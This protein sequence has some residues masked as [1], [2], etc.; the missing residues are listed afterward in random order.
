[1][2]FEKD[3]FISYAHIDEVSVDK[4][5]EGWISKFHETLQS[6]VAKKWGHTP[7]IWRDDRLKGND[8]F[9]P[10]ILSQFPKLKLLVSIITP[11][12]LES[13]WCGFSNFTA[14][15][16][17]AEPVVY[18]FKSSDGTDFYRRQITIDSLK[19]NIRYTVFNFPIMYNYR[20][21]FGKSNKEYPSWFNFK[22]GPS[23][24]LFNTISD[25]NA[26][27]SFGGLYQ[28]DGDGIVY[29]DPFDNGS[30]YNFFITAD[31]INAQN[32][33]PGADDVF[34]KL[35]A[36]SETYDF[37]DNKN[38]QSEQKN[39]TRIALALNAGF[40]LQ[41]Q[42][43]ENFAFK[44]GAHFMYAPLPERKEKYKPIDKTSD[45]FQSVY[46][47]TAKTSYSAFGINIGLVYR[48]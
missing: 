6:Y 43:N 48:F 42:L 27:I 4:D 24:M 25:Y 33:N 13:K 7:V 17:L 16:E 44:M 41:K 1:M 30:T 29:T 26:N 14:D 46:N 36:N 11:R 37:A 31:S 39:E 32:P 47:S 40:D 5:L 28:T 22:I 3:I 15:Y 18:T 8:F 2:K 35:K 38:Y 45:E 10:E 12:Y 20:L 9:A 23:V 19:E 21:F 34:N